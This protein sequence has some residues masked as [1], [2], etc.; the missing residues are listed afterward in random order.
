LTDQEPNN[1]T[2]IILTIVNI[3]IVFLNFAVSYYINILAY[4]KRKK[5]ERLYQ[6]NFDLYKFLIVNNITQFINPYQAIQDILKILVEKRFS[7]DYTAEVFRSNLEKQIDELYKIQDNFNTQNVYLFECY[8]VKMKDEF[9]LISEELFNSITS[10]FSKLSSI[11][12]EKNSPNVFYNRFTSIKNKF[13]NA[14][15]ALIKKYHPLGN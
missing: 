14:I 2:I 4:N 15:F 3:L 10:L 13:I 12:G 7:K 11:E 9:M 8:S 1:S 6:S 5:E